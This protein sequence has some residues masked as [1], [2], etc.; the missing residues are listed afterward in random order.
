MLWG[1]EQ[2]VNVFCDADDE[3]T[4]QRCIYVTPPSGLYSIAC[5]LYWMGT[6]QDSRA[7]SNPEPG[8][9]YL[10]RVLKHN[11]YTAQDIYRLDLY[12]NHH[13]W[14]NEYY[15][16]FDVKYCAYATR[17]PSM[18]RQTPPRTAESVSSRSTC[19]LR[20]ERLRKT[21]NIAKI[22]PTQ[23]VRAQSA[24]EQEVGLCPAGGSVK[25]YCS[26][27][28]RCRRDFTV[29]YAANKDAEEGAGDNGGKSD[30]K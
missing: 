17:C 24:A 23:S 3:V 22:S 8:S 15:R 4:M 11:N 26:G 12:V 9:I 7:L 25:C 1:A 14:L 21:E 27:S 28:C 30:D 10:R 29:N 20:E 16:W 5:S 13:Q 19:S 6:T 18:H 2:R